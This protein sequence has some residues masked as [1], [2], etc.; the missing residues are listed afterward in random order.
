VFCYANA[1]V[2]KAE[3][4]D[5]VRFVEFWQARTGTLSEKLVFDSKLTTYQPRPPQTSLASSASSPC[6]GASAGVLAELELAPDSAWRRIELKGVHRAYRTPE[7]LERPITVTDYTAPIRQIATPDVGVQARSHR[8]VRPSS[9]VG[10]VTA[11]SATIAALV[12]VAAA[13]PPAAVASS[14]AAST[15]ATFSVATKSASETFTYLGYTF[16]VGTP[17]IGKA[18][19][20]EIYVPV[21]SRG[22]VTKTLRD[23]TK[24]RSARLLILTKL[25]G[26]HNFS[27]RFAGAKV[28]AIG[29]VTTDYGLTATITLSFNKL[30]Q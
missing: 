10:C 23:G 22:I 26:H 6:A 2:R 8:R 7:I 1:G 11:R 28:K 19:T 29:F 3:Q 20:I 13:M 24:L 25:R 21:T 16:D 15:R 12:A 17:P 9:I 27:Y 5:E 4:A 14:P 18:G 30:T